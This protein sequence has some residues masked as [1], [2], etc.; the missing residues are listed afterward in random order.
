MNYLL[1]AYDN[2]AQMLADNLT[3]MEWPFGQ[4]SAHVAQNYTTVQL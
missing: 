4:R 3:R 1:V 2:E